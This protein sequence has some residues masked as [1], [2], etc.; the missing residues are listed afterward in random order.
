MRRALFLAALLF[1]GCGSE[2]QKPTP[3]PDTAKTEN[4]TAQAKPS[5]ATTASAPVASGSASSSTPPGVV[6]DPAT[7]LEGGAALEKLPVRATAPGQ[8]F[9][10]ALR[11]RLAAPPP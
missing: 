10:P 5:A 3:A 1:A 8:T 9:D 4:T 7:L 6:G 2:S 11:Q